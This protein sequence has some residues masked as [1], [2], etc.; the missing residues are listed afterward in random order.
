MNAV[1]IVGLGNMGS[2]MARRLA[3][4][5]HTIFGF[6]P[7]PVPVEAITRCDDLASVARSAGTI[8][9]SLPDGAA[10]AAVCQELASSPGRAVTAVTDTST[11]GP[12]AAI[13]AHAILATAGITY[14]DAPVSGGIQGAESGSLSMMIAA[15][16]ETFERY[17]PLLAPIAKN[18]FHVGERPGQGQAMKLLN[19]FLSATAILATSEAIAFGVTQGL[20]PRLMLDVLNVSSG[21]NTATSDKFPR[22]VLDRSYDFGFATRLMTKDVTLYANSVHATESAHS[23]GDVVAQLWQQFEQVAPASDFTRIYEWISA[24]N[25]S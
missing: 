9:L 23:V 3:G 20:D 24:A 4:A 5:G 18:R 11:I 1:G 19:N 16:R 10:V 22:S 8:V 17:D 6:D 21:R 14:I 12:A 2:R 7:S 15:S 25:A 13:H